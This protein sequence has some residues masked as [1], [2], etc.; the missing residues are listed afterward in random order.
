MLVEIKGEY[1]SDIV[2]FDDIAQKLF[3]MMG[4]SGNLEGALQ[5]EDLAQA[6][7]K[8]ESA[9]SN[10]VETPNDDD[11]DGDA[12]VGLRTRALPLMDLMQRNITDGGY[13]M[14]QGQ[15]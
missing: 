4:L 2:M 15:K 8:L 10:H 3:K 12:P 5:T 1:G 14:W 13:L 6:L 11:S 7:A 9:L